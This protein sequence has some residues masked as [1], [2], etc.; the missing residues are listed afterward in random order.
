MSENKTGKYFKYAIG[1][2]VLV[3]IGIL[4]ALQI[5]N[6][7]EKNIEENKIQTIYGI[8]TKD[9]ESDVVKIQGIIDLYKKREPYLQHILDDKLTK[10]DYIDSTY[11]NLITYAPRISVS[12]RGFNLLKNTANDKAVK[13][14]LQLSLTE[15][16][17]LT[18]GRFEFLH[19]YMISDIEDNFSNWKNNYTWYS[20]YIQRKNLDMFIEYTLDN[21]NYKNRIANYYFVH[22]NVSI[23][24]LQDF[25]SQADFILNELENSND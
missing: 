5:N 16:Y 6:W 14:S 12:T 3:V 8:I 19:N 24:Y 4:I 23:N 25:L 15:F 1:E 9:L 21:T 11:F 22:Y 10:E 2:I 17:T 7:N 20:D 13:D 18:M